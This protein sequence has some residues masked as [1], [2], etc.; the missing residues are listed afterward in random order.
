MEQK[1]KTFFYGILAVLT[2]SLILGACSG[3]SGASTPT[4]DR[5]RL[6]LSGQVYIQNTEPLKL[7]FNSKNDEYKGNLNISDGGLD[8]IGQIKNG[9]LSYSVGIPPNLSPIS[10]G[11][12]L[13]YLNGI[14]PSL[15]LKFSPED[16]NANGVVLVTDSEEYS[17]LLKYL[18]KIDL[19]LTK[20]TIKINIKMVNYMYVD[21][22]LQITADKFSY[23]YENPELPFPIKLTSEK[24]NL[25][26]KQG[27]NS[28]YSE[29]TA[30]S[31]IPP[32]FILMM[33][34]PSDQ[35]S[36]GPDLSTLRPTGNL[37][38]SVGDPGN[39]EWTLIPQ[40]SDI[41]EPEYPPQPPEP[42]KP[43]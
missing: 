22:D 8:G 14:Y 29:I 42:P 37:N 2:F 20:L 21:K 33:Q 1:A 43:F 31:N 41:D 12:S 25:S 5:S 6:N 27:W 16:V 30:Q 39:L 11:G 18:L 13:D 34:V 28:L 40:S 4:P 23:D 35:D 32:D 15:N 26:L 3:D 10:E 9:W 19:E 36:P 17:G 7:L 38:M 24:I